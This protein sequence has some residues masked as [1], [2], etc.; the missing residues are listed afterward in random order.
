MWAHRWAPPTKAT[1]G[2]RVGLRL[3]LRQSFTQLAA[4]LYTHTATSSSPTMLRLCLPPWV[5]RAQCSGSQERNADRANLP[6]AGSVEE[7]DVEKNRWRIATMPR[8]RPRSPMYVPMDT[9]RPHPDIPV[10]TTF[11]TRPHP[12]T[13]AA[14]MPIG[15]VSGIPVTHGHPH[16]CFRTPRP[17]RP[18][19]P[20]TPSGSRGRAGMGTGLP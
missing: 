4:S 13:H 16:G 15:S 1:P 12:G 18:Q 20:C 10:L 14:P 6:P 9:R 19:A 8:L 17:P 3:P 2:G 5:T 7:H 11:P